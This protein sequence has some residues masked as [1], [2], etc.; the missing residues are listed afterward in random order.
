MKKG[1]PEPN[2]ATPAPILDQEGHTTAA[3]VSITIE[4]R[5]HM[6]HYEKTS[7][8]AQTEHPFFTREEWLFSGR[9]LNQPYWSWV[10]SEDQKLNTEIDCNESY[11]MGTR[12][13]EG[14]ILT[15]KAQEKTA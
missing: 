14:A 3:G 11:S 4:M 7:D 8:S 10:H 15:N 5:G 12:F 1:A 6:K 9:A 13:T 2:G